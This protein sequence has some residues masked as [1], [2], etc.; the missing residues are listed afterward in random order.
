MYKRVKTRQSYN[1][2]I[3]FEM[4]NGPVTYF[5]R[6][7]KFIKVTLGGIVYRLAVNTH[8]PNRNPTRQGVRI[9]D[10]ARPYATARIIEV[11][12]IVRKVIIIPPAQGHQAKVL[13]IPTHMPN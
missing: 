5:G 3:D 13:E 12:A 8:Y 4:G 6:I 7:H 9:I 1:V 2:A 11:T 10:I